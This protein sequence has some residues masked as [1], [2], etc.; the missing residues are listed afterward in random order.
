MCFYVFL[1]PEHLFSH[2]TPQ[3]VTSIQWPIMF[4]RIKKFWQ[5]PRNCDS[6]VI[7]LPLYHKSKKGWVVY[8]GGHKSGKGASPGRD[9]KDM[10]GKANDLTRAVQR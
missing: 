5:I 9:K 6:K 10:P 3:Q 8:V 1:G 4:C 2:C 7:L